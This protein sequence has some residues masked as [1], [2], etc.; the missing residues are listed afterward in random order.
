MSITLILLIVCL[1]IIIGYQ[2]KENIETVRRREAEDETERV[3]Q[4]LAEAADKL[5]RSYSKVT[6]QT[7]GEM[8][9][10]TRR[11]N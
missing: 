5:S 8:P 6:Y 11:E 7:R 2:L 4:E 3:K 10:L 1:L 9:K